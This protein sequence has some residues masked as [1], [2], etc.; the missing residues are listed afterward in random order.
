MVGSLVLVLDIEFFSRARKLYEVALAELT[1][2]QVLLNA[3][4][5]HE[6]T[7]EE[8]TATPDRNI[9]TKE[10]RIF[11]VKKIQSVYGP[12]DPNKRHRKKIAEE[13][14][15]MIVKVGVTPKSTIIVW[16]QSNMDLEPVQKF[17]VSPGYHDLLP[18]YMPVSP[19]GV[20]GAHQYV[21]NTAP[22]SALDFNLV[23]TIK[24]RLAQQ[25]LGRLTAKLLRVVSRAPASCKSCRVRAC[26]VEGPKTSEWRA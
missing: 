16:Q 24:E 6:C 22:G 14:A 19:K 5:D 25:S 13:T 11:E 3:R 2:G 7:P 10:A 15:E 20:S 17:L 8:L 23:G 18:Q 21:Q 9:L 4:V 26:L 12:G 1:P